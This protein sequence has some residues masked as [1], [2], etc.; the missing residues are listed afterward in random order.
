M[1]SD[2]E[3]THISMI[4]G[5]TPAQIFGVLSDGWSYVV[6]LSARRTSRG[7]HSRADAPPTR[8]REHSDAG[9]ISRR[10]SLAVAEHR[11]PGCDRSSM[12]LRHCQGALGWSKNEA[13]HG[14][15]RA[16]DDSTATAS[17]PTT[18]SS[19]AGPPAR[20]VTRTGGG[21][22]RK[23]PGSTPIKGL[24]N[25]LRHAASAC[26]PVPARPMARRVRRTSDQPRRCRPVPGR[27]RHR[28]SIAG[29]AVRWP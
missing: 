5:A 14:R 18:A 16:S 19:S 11:I 10:A 20:I 27:T 8:L 21:A 12:Q 7:R 9:H 17:T 3:L 25:N 29:G 15:C 6:G 2:A 26:P 13:S 22:G 23:A 1:S 4:M 28:C 24:V